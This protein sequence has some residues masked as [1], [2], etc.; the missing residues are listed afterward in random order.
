VELLR[1]EIAAATF[2]APIVVDPLLGGAG[3]WTLRQRPAAP[4]GLATITAVRLTLLG[5][6]NV[7]VNTITTLRSQ[8]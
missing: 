3:E 8:L 2:V 7:V 5:A 6:N 4:G 1:G